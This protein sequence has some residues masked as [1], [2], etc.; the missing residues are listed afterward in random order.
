MKE[1]IPFLGYPEKTISMGTKGTVEAYIVSIADHDFIIEKARH[2]YKTKDGEIIETPNT[3]VKLGS[4]RLSPFL[5]V[6][7]TLSWEPPYS[8]EKEEWKPLKGNV[9]LKGYYIVT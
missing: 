3:N 7:I 4:K 5:P 8:E 1:A 6:K 9:Q 2:V